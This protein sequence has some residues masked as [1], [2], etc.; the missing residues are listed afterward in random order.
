MQQTNKQTKKR[1]HM[2]NQSIYNDNDDD[3]TSVQTELTILVVCCIVVY[4]AFIFMILVEMYQNERLNALDI[5]KRELDIEQH[6]MT[7]S[8]T[9]ELTGKSKASEET[10]AH[11]KLFSSMSKTQ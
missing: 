4:L 10:N 9:K 11:A 6:E 2:T 1:M 3:E 8:L 5:Q 7:L